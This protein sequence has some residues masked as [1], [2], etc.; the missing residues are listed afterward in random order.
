LVIFFPTY[1]LIFIFVHLFILNILFIVFVDAQQDDELSAPAGY[2]F[3][4][5]PTSNHTASPPKKTTSTNTHPT[6]TTEVAAPPTSLQRQNSKGDMSSKGI[7][8][9]F[10]EVLA[11]HLCLFCSHFCLFCFSSA[12]FC[13]YFVFV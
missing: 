4:K 1:F 10:V 11:G 12:K 3:S 9:D 7:I 13:S 5:Q 6:L 8:I 2:L